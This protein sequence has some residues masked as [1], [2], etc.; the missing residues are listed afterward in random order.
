MVF[1]TPPD[2]PRIQF[3][4]SFSTSS[5]I[6]AFNAIDKFLFG[7]SLLELETSII[8]PYGIG[9]RD[10]KIYICDTM[11]P[12]L[13]V[14]DL[15]Q[16]TMKAFQPFGRGTLRKPINLTFDDN[17]NVYVA[18]T[19]REQVVVFSPDLKYLYA[20]SS[21]S[22]KPLD[23]TVYGDTLLIT[24]YIDRNI[25]LW[26]VK[27]RRMIGEFPPNNSEL[28]DS[29]RIFVPYSVDVDQYGNIYIT[30]FGQFRVQKFDPRG[31]L[32]R[33][34]GGLGKSLGK[35]ARPK[36]I[37]VDRDE[38]LY[39]VDAA[40][41]N[42][43]IFDKEGNL[44]MFFGGA[45]QRPGNMYLPAQVTIDYDNL[46]YFEPYVLPGYILDFLIL[47]TNQYGP[48]KIT[49]YGFIHPENG[50]PDEKF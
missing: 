2:E 29:I 19:E 20:L 1:P 22:L 48:D 47:V 5:D 23:V 46:S 41:E 24:D 10:G 49:V 18:D 6:K 12:G 37:S 34:Y 35:F 44:L 26:S 3:L 36:G 17:G 4:K 42:I 38:R 39:V 15:N 7:S 40:F 28:P 43:Q 50:N 9:I 45:Y 27:R 30:D 11:L 8:K 14:I 31:N 13:I 16:Q 25:E 21:K 33:S 32:I